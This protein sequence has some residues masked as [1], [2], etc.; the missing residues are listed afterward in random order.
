[1]GKLMVSGKVSSGMLLAALGGIRW[2]GWCPPCLYMIEFDR[3][4][5]FLFLLVLFGLS[6]A[7]S[8]ISTCVYLDF[9]GRG[10]VYR[11]PLIKVGPYEK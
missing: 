10:L 9:G 11:I 5:S 8:L 3:S 1:M 2:I 6:R 7:A 4:T